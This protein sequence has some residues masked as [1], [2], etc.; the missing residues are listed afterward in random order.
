VVFEASRIAPSTLRKSSVA[1]FALA[2]DRETSAIQ[3]VGAIQIHP[4]EAGFIQSRPLVLRLPAK[5]KT[6]GAHPANHD[7]SD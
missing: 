3:A 2:H 7:G 4:D 6:D 1:S 5:P